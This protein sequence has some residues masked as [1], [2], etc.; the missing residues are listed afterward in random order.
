MGI[1]EKLGE[2]VN[3]ELD[4]EEQIKREIVKLHLL[5]ETD[6]INDTELSEKE[7]ELRQRLRNIKEQKDS[8]EDE[9]IDEE[10]IEFDIAVCNENEVE[11]LN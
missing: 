1:A 4:E 7:A 2:H 11:E 5:Y 6:Q 3:R 9:D 8:Y 10:E